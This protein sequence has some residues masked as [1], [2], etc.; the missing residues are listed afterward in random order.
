MSVKSY[1]VA[2][3]I[4]AVGAGLLPADNASA[5]ASA[6][7]SAQTTQPSKK[8]FKLL[9]DSATAAADLDVEG[10]DSEAW[11][12]G[13]RGG[14]VEVGM[15]LGFMNL[16]GTLLEHEQ[17][18]YKYTTESTYWGD[19][20]ITGQTA[21]SPVLRIG[22]TVNPWLTVESYGGVSFSE[23]SSTYENRRVRKNEQGAVPVEDPPLGE[24]D[25]EARSLITLQAGLDLLVYPLNFSG[26]GSG[27]WHPYVTGQFGGIWYDM[28]SD[29]TAGPAGSGDVALG[30]GLRLLADRN[31]S[32]RLEATYHMN[33]IEFEP[34]EYFLETD[35]GTTL[36]PLTEYPIQEDGT[37]VEQPVTS[38][39]SQ[40][41][42][43]LVWSIG[44][45]GSF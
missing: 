26:D 38:F 6:P 2:V 10:A 13:V 30:G 4:L 5:Q 24:F 43:Y 16:S 12:P 28:N 40:D 44:F 3:C 35:E 27:R 45:Q 1:L 11:V 17:M 23:Y 19:V 22:Y 18:I 20:E 36:V 33:T 7:D 32:L 29:F 14:T 8:T 31:V 39:S 41:L 15:S 9:R 25:T 21:F 34:A 37:Y 42:S